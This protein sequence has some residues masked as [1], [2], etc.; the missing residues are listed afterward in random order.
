MS[1]VAVSHPPSVNCTAVDAV[2]RCSESTV[3]KRLVLLA[4]ARHVNSHT[5]T[6]YPSNAT[7]M[8]LSGASDASTVRKSVSA[9]IELGELERTG[10]LSQWGTSVYRLPKLKGWVDTTSELP[11]GKSGETS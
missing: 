1:E 11:I 6:A 5:G 10:D 8:R 3:T 9:L 2:M 4:I 7:I